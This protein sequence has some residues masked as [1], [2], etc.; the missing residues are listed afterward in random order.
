MANGVPQFANVVQ[1]FL[2]LKTKQGTEQSEAPERC[3]LAL[4]VE[5]VKEWV[6]CP[7][8]AALV[9]HTSTGQKVLFIFVGGRIG[10]VIVSYLSATDLLAINSALVCEPDPSD[11]L[12]LRLTG[13]NLVSSMALDFWSQ[14]HNH[15]QQSQNGPQPA[16][17]PKT[18]RKSIFTWGR[19]PSAGTASKHPTP[20]SSSSYSSQLSTFFGST[21]KNSTGRPAECQRASKQ[22]ELSQ[23]DAK[24]LKRLM[25]TLRVK[26]QS[27]AAVDL[28]RHQ[29]SVL[30]ASPSNQSSLSQQKPLCDW[31]QKYRIDMMRPSEVLRFLPNQSS[32][33]PSVS[34]VAS[35]ASVTAAKAMLSP[36]YA[37]ISRSFGDL[38]DDTD[39][40]LDGG[41]AFYSSLSASTSS[42]NTSS[43]ELSAEEGEEVT[44][45]VSGV[46][47]SIGCAD[48]PAG[49]EA[50]AVTL[51]PSVAATT[52]NNGTAGGAAVASGDEWKSG[53]CAAPEHRVGALV[54]GLPDTPESRANNFLRR[55]KRATRRQNRTLTVADFLPEEI[56]R[57]RL[58]SDLFVRRRLEEREADYCSW[59]TLKVFIGSWNV[60]GRQDTAVKLDEWMS[61]PETHQPPA[62]IY[63]FGFQE[64]DLS[65]G[66]MALNKAT[67]SPFEYQWLRQ[68][69]SAHGGL[70]RQSPA[71]T[72]F[73][74]RSGGVARRWSKQTGGG[75]RR[76]PIVRLAG[77]LLIVYVSRRLYTR[78]HVSEICLQSVPTGMFNVMGNKGAVGLRLTVYNCSMCFVNCHLAAGVANKERRIQDYT[79]I[80]RK[81]EFERRTSTGEIQFLRIPEHDQLFFFG[82]MNYRIVGLTPAE[83]VGSIIRRTYEPLLKNDELLNLRN[84]GRIMQNFSEGKITFPPTYKF[85]LITNTYCLTEGR[86]PS[87]CDRILWSGKYIE[88]L[89]YRSH[90][91]FRISDHKPVSALF[92]VGSRCVDRYLF[93]KAYEAVIRSQDL[94]YNMSLP[95]AT[96]STQ[97]VEFGPV[98]FDDICQDSIVIRN[99][100]ISAL[101]FR[102]TQEGAASFPPWLTVTP[103]SA[104]VEKDASCSITLDV[105]VNVDTVA[106]LQNGTCDLSCII[107]LTLVG[108]KDYFISVSGQFVPTCFGLPLSLLLKIPDT[109]V[110]S[111]PRENLQKLVGC[112]FAHVANRRRSESVSVHSVAYSLLIFLSTLP[113]PVVPYAFQD[114]CL[115][116]NASFPQAA[117]ALACL[118]IDYQNLFYYLV[119]FL[120]R[121]IA[122]GKKNGT[123]LNMLSNSFAEIMF[124]DMPN[125]PQPKQ[126]QQAPNSRSQSVSNSRQEAKS[127]FLRLFLITE[128]TDAL[129]QI[130][131]LCA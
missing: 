30:G 31:L 109:P 94:V 21:K 110:A 129:K 119:S 85:D 93:A 53:D 57:T 111:I 106:A 4:D 130:L 82:D 61:F 121:C 88:Q 117:Q 66:G 108:G 16:A 32:R 17:S 25:R 19:K 68:L 125:A 37:R 23:A 67:A 11:P 64:L 91:E 55:R 26:F 120:R 15:Q 6:R 27:T 90:G 49:V 80:M 47:L 39:G 78:A 75:F 20:P 3:L 72:A 69:E 102:F 14:Q 13:L 1:E 42:C 107:V 76:L 97:E 5:V 54:T 131:Q 123:E 95:Q 56:Y 50:T 29:L 83:N 70:L 60:N 46:D 74:D 77:L 112:V 99:T 96:L 59:K 18:S 33:S 48:L 118:P 45:T 126:K 114:R 79:E 103:M 89:L 38:L 128:P 113:E 92:K 28:F 41:S 43:L 44:T 58:D 63:V 34:S 127:A 81:M 12:V 2:D 40:L 122:H 35:S 65:L 10:E 87:Y 71:P 24:L 62:D 9:E 98:R 22:D 115:A 104:I 84:S 73:G 116:A 7:R 51:I 124:R 36:T 105:Y 101:Q 8:I 52:T 86:L 100:G